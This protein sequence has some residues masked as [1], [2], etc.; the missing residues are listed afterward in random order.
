MNSKGKRIGQIHQIQDRGKSI[1]EAKRDMEVAI[2]IREAIVGKTINEGDILYVDIPEHHAR[3]L[4]KEYIDML[5][6]DEREVLKEIIEIK[7][8]NNPLWAR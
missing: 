5:S 7:R 4:L 1:P 2:S 8:K 3:K 6:D